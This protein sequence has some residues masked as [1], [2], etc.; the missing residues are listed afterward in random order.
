[1][2]RRLRSADCWASQRGHG[3]GTPFSSPDSP[4]C[5]DFRVENETKNLTPMKGGSLTEE[6]SL[7]FDRASLL[8]FKMRTK[9]EPQQDTRNTWSGRRGRCGLPCGAQRARGRLRVGARPTLCTPGSAFSHMYPPNTCCKY[10]ALQC[11]PPRRS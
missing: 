11:S 7:S 2:R 10:S 5:P 4:Y 6:E 9:Q 1:M 3:G 8:L